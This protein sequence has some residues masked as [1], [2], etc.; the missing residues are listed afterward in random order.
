MS[1]DE[2]VGAV[3]VTCPQVLPF[4]LPGSSSV[5]RTYATGL[6]DAS[7]PSIPQR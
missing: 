5:T 4:Q 2:D 6:P 3:P 7:H 1:S